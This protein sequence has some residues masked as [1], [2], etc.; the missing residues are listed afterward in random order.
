ML[1][2]RNNGRRTHRKGWESNWKVIPNYESWAK[3]FRN[4]ENNLL[5]QH[6]YDIDYEKVGNIEENTRVFSLQNGRTGAV[7]VEK[8][9]TASNRNQSLLYALKNDFVFGVQRNSFFSENN[10]VRIYHQAEGGESA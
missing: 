6:Y 2:Y 4:N 9:Y 8:D 7:V 1:V 5:N 3:Y 10:G